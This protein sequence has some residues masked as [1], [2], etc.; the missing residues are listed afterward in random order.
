MASIPVE[1]LSFYKSLIDEGYAQTFADGLKTEHA[2]SSAHNREVTPEKVEARRR[3]V[4]SRG[5]S[6]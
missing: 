2:R 4:M 5:R 1:T 6:Q 3:Q